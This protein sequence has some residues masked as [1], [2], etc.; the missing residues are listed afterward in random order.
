M[1]RRCLVLLFVAATARGADAP[2][3]TLAG[4]VPQPVVEVSTARAGERTPQAVSR[5]KRE[6][7]V[8]LDWGQDTPMALATQPGAFAYSDAGNGIGYSYLTLR[9]IGRA[10]V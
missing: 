4:V 2:P 9:E 7:L 6:D 1:R 5:L 3:D 10:H 8:K